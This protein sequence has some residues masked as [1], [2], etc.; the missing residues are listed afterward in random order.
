MEFLVQGENMGLGLMEGC[1]NPGNIADQ[2]SP[3]FS[4]SMVCLEQEGFTSGLQGMLPR[5]GKLE[6][7]EKSHLSKNLGDLIPAVF[8]FHSCSG[9][10]SPVPSRDKQKPLML[11][12]ALIEFNF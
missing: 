12:C 10:L 7:T 3:W 4:L 1:R 8:I 6:Q 5:P 11:C 9:G 2:T